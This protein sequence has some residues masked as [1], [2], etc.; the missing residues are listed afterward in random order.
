MS[1][2]PA[3]PL[4]RDAAGIEDDALADEAY[5]LLL[6]RAFGAVPDHDRKP[7]RPR[8]SLPDAEKR[9]HA[10]LFHVFDVEDFDLDTE[11]L[12]RFRLFGE[13]DG[14]EDIGRLV[15]EIAGEVDAVRNGLEWVERGLRL[16]RMRRRG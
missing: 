9:A 13:F 2:M 7:R 11:F 6:L 8:A 12:Q 15:D 10:E 5:R 3:A 4:D 1:S 16:I 14:A